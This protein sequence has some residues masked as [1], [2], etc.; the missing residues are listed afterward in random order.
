M[1]FTARRLQLTLKI[2]GVL[3]YSHCMIYFRMQIIT[4]KRSLII[5]V[6]MLA[7]VCNNAS[8]V[9]IRYLLL[10]QGFVLLTAANFYLYSSLLGLIQQNILYKIFFKMVIHITSL[11]LRKVYLMQMTVSA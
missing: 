1:C 8:C 3:L 4:E 11:S 7:Q 2:S 5:S 6:M 9:F 10:R